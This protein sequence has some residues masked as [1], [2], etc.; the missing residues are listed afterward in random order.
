MVDDCK[1]NDASLHVSTTFAPDNWMFNGIGTI[2][3]GVPTV[4]CEKSDK[5]MLYPLVRT[6]P[7]V[8]VC[9]ITPVTEVAKGPGKKLPGGPRSGLL[10]TIIWNTW[11]V[12]LVMLMISLPARCLSKIGRAS[13]RERV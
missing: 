1:L 6:A 9:D 8:C 3:G 2:T 5:M 12:R 13:C 10:A 4:I 7:L 11:P